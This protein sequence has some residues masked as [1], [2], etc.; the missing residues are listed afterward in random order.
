VLTVRAAVAPGRRRL[1]GDPMAEHRA[2]LAALARHAAQPDSEPPI[3]VRVL[4]GDHSA[5]TP[6]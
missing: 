5:S 2:L 4:D 6:S 3:S 1:H